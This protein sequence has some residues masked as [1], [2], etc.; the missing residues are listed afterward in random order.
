MESFTLHSLKGDYYTLG[1][2][3][4]LLYLQ[5]PV[6]IKNVQYACSYYQG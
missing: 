3:E 4:S 2:E 1:L 5:A 6:F